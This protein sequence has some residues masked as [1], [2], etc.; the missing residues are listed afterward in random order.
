MIQSDNAPTQYKNRHD[1]ALL[2]KPVNEL[3]LRIISTYVAPGRVKGTIDATWSFVVKNVFE[4][5]IVTQEIFFDT[6]AKIVDCLHIKNPHFY[7]VSIDP[8]LLARK[9]HDY[10]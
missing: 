10:Y 3:H 6:S 2:Q 8:G 4:R 9:R 5:D 7:Y 1:F